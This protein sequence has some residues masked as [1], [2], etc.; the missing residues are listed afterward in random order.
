MLWVNQSIAG[1]LECER[2][3]ESQNYDLALKE[4]RQTDLYDELRARYIVAL[5]FENGYGSTLKSESISCGEYVDLGKLGYCDAHLKTASCQRKRIKP[6]TDQW[7]A[8]EYEALAEK[9]EKKYISCKSKLEAEEPVING[10]NDPIEE[11]NTPNLKTEPDSE[12]KPKPKPSDLN[13]CLNNFNKG[14]YKEAFITCK[15]LADYGQKDARF[16]LGLM[17]KKGQGVEQDLEKAIYW[18]ELAAN[19]NVYDAAFEL[20]YLYYYDRGKFFSY[21]KAKDWFL[22]AAKNG[23]A[24]AQYRLG[25]MF[26][27]GYGTPIKVTHAIYWLNQSAEQGNNLIIIMIVLIIWKCYW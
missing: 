26:Y 8:R 21:L 17:Y 4:C 25:V 9:E 24:L 22:K 12:P 20:G 15:P 18:F 23:N 5:I 6:S 2:A 1:M 13:N 19:Q 11:S 7:T 3:F 10:N 16:N 14:S 27:Y